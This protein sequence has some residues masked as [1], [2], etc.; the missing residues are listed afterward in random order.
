MKLDLS[1]SN[2]RMYC[3]LV[4][5]LALSSSHKAQGWVKPKGKLKGFDLGQFVLFL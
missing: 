1:K 2:E 5:K 4:T 3:T